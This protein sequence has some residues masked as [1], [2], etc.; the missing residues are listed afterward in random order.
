MRRPLALSALAVVSLLGVGCADDIDSNEELA[1]E[2]LSQSLTLRFQATQAGELSLKSSGKLLSC[3]ERFQGVAGERVSCERAG[4][5]VEVIVKSDDDA[6]VVVRDVKSKRGYYTCSRAG[7]VEGVPA[8]MK[9]TLTKLR[10]RGTGG[11]S[12]PFDSA[13]EG[14]SVPN[15]HWVDGQATLLR[16][17]EPRTPAQFDEL[18]AVGIE[19]VLIFKNTTGQDDVGKEIAAWSLPSGDVL[20]VPFQWKDFSGF[21][22]P[23]EQ[24]L[25]ALRFIRAAEAAEKKLF[26]HCTVGEDRTGYLAAMHGLL[27]EKADARAAFDA[28]MCEHGY[29]AGNPQKPGFVLGKLEDGLTPLYRQMAFLVSEGKLTSKLESTACESEPTVPD[30]FMSEPLACGTSTTLVP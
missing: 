25:E 6:V 3:T 16:G 8:E 30:D 9:C 1:T 28:D 17:M 21:S 19:K 11:L 23:C 29:G 4:E 7:D 2:S 24:T 26:F 12:S 5:S 27:F 14:V 18:R 20:H 22:E 13:V 10:P 15:S